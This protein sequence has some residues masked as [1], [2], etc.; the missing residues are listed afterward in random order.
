MVRI[1]LKGIAKAK[2][3]GRIYYYAWRGGPR[4]RGEP[5]SPEFVASYNEAV[6]GLRTPDATRFSALIALYKASDD[7]KKLANSTKRNW[8]RWL[9]RIGEHFG[10]LRTA[11]FDRPEKIRPGNSAPFD[12]PPNPLSLQLIH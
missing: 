11:Q 9:D 8:S 3:K 6:E 5:G 4:L 2:A 1:D 10:G 12:V 7:Y